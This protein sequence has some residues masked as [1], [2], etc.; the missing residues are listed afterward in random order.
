MAA[1]RGQG[2]QVCLVPHTFADTVCQ[3]AWS[4]ETVQNFFRDQPHLD[5]IFNFAVDDSL[6]GLIRTNAAVPPGHAVPR[7][8]L[9]GR[10]LPAYNSANLRDF[11]GMAGYGA[12]WEN[13]VRDVARLGRVVHLERLP[14]RLEPHALPLAGR[15]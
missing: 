4:F 13:I 14:G 11:Q 2:Y 5:G 3:M 1:L 6:G 10:R 9:H 12:M 8:D 15:S 7:Q